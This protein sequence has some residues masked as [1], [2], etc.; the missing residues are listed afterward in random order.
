MI[1]PIFKTL[2]VGLLALPI[3]ATA[4]REGK[5]VYQQTIQTKMDDSRF[6]ERMKQM[7]EEQRAQFKKRMQSWGKSKTVLMFTPEESL[8]RNFSAEK[9]A[10]GEAEW[11]EPQGRGHWRKMR[12]QTQVYKSLVKQSLVEQE[13]FFDKKFLITGEKETPQWKMMGVREEVAGYACQKAVWQQNDS[14]TIT[15]WFSPQIPVPTGPGKL[16][17]LPGLILKVDKNEGELTI[18]AEKVDLRPLEAGEIVIPEKG[19]EV[20]REE[21]SEIVRKK[22]QE[23]REMRGQR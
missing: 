8:Y 3:I 18:V 1:H 6:E 17:A 2:L 20:T 5:I 13:E 16:G 9:D 11:Q 14:T 15:A 19:K 22:R 10:V 7:T 21:F 12:P 23:M 4:Q